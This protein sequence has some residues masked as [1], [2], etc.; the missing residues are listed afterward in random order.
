MN[1]GGEQRWG[2]LDVMVHSPFNRNSQLITLSSKKTY[3]IIG[4]LICWLSTIGMAPVL[5]PST[6]VSVR[7]GTGVSGVSRKIFWVK[8]GLL[9]FQP[10]PSSL[11][12]TLWVKCAARKCQLRSHVCS[13]GSIKNS[14]KD[15]KETSE[16]LKITPLSGTIQCT[17]VCLSPSSPSHS[18]SGPSVSV[19]DL[20]T[21]CI[22]FH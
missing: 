12:S 9:M 18:I 3:N 4:M 1:R 5:S 7:S 15:E 11:L 6:K 8:P 17:E 13:V 14:Y 16:E 20:N 22:F 2:W 19:H 10:K 21:N